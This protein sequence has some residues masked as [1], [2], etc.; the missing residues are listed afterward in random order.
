MDL[1]LERLA[2]VT[3]HALMEPLGDLEPEIR[4]IN[5]AHPLAMLPGFAF[6]ALQR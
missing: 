1:K 5:D 4:Y 6:G 2:S 3:N